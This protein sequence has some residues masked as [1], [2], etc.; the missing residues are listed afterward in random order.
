VEIGCSMICAADSRFIKMRPVTRLPAAD[1][2]GRLA[3]LL[4]FSRS[5]TFIEATSGARPGVR[6]VRMTASGFS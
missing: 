3:P 2:D 4:Y 5:F 6:Y 1:P